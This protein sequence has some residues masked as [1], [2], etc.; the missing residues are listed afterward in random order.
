MTA[1]LPSPRVPTVRGAA[2]QRL[3]TF[4]LSQGYRTLAA[5][6]FP[7][8]C[9]LALALSAWLLLAFPERL[10][11]FLG[12]VIPGLLIV[13]AWQKRDDAVLPVLP[14][15]VL[16]QIVVYV[17][18]LVFPKVVADWR[19]EITP[20]LLERCTLPLLLWFSA[21]WVGWLAIPRA[22]A[23][24]R[25]GSLFSFVSSGVGRIPHG[26]LVLTLVLSFLLNQ[27][28]FWEV[29]GDFGRVLISPIRTASGLA[30][31]VGC[32]LGSYEWS[33]GS[34]Q[35]RWLWFGL[36]AAMLSG[37]LSSLLLSAVQAPLL[38]LML[39]LW[40]GRARQALAITLSLLLIFAFLQQGKY[41]LRERYWSGSGLTPPSNPITLAQEWIEASLTPVKSDKKATDR[42]LFS[43]RL[44]NL[45]NLLYVEQ[46]LSRGTPTLG[47]ESL[48]VIPEVLV[49]RL[50]NQDKVRSQQGQVILNL[51]FGRQRSLKDTFTAYIAWGLLPEGIGNFGSTAGP[52]LFGFATGGL[53]RCTENL[54]RGQRLLTTPG[55][56]SV[57]LM[58]LWLT[59][60]EM[61]AST[62]LAAAEQLILLVL[63]SSW[64]LGQRAA[65]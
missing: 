19:V 65:A 30:S 59:S 13:Q 12:A 56:L 31:V 41:V 8:L 4:S 27:S 54:S 15:Y 51:H 52:L 6:V 17:L 48:T 63:V 29:F 43:S 61:V 24:F 9:L 45:Q 46:S 20:A 36:V 22:W 25:R 53:I 28:E 1:S 23:Q 60:F 55:L 32:F 11:P 40:L 44:N 49:P 10:L 57:V 62:F 58:V 33:R 47:G 35:S 38:A 34:L 16:V 3:D 5:Q 2:L 18:P 37:G 64:L 42:G 7:W 14:L 26:L 50:F 21:L 39:G